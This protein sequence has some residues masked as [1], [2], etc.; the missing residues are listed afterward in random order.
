MNTNEPDRQPLDPLDEAFYLSV[1]EDALSAERLQP[2]AD[3]DPAQVE[4]LLAGGLPQAFE[5]ATANLMDVL[6]KQAPQQLRVMRQQQ[7]RFERR[8]RKRWGTA[9]DQY[10]ILWQCMQ[11]QGSTFNF[12]RG[13]G[14]DPLGSALVGLHAKACRVAWEV[15][16][17]LSAGLGMGALARC[18][19]LHEMAVLT[20]VLADWHGPAPVLI[21]D[22]AERFAARGHVI[23]Y[24][25]AL[26]YQRNAA[27]IDHEPFTDDEMD[28]FK[29]DRDAV[30]ARFGKLIAKRDYGWATG[31]GGF[32]QP[33]FAD[34]ETVA[35]LAHLRSYYKWA[36]HEVHA[37]AHGIAANLITH[38][39]GQA[40]LAGPSNVGLAD[41]GQSA[42]ISLHQITTTM[43]VH[44]GSTPG[45]MTLVGL[46]AVQAML[47]R[48][49]HEFAE[50]ERAIRRD[51][52]RLTRRRQRQERRRL[53]RRN[54]LNRISRQ[55]RA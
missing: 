30:V 37:D 18:R 34:L 15:H 46:Q 1:L 32:E 25:D 21:P 19:T 7:R 17:L 11:E 24:K 10:R 6:G 39:G 23:A 44:G 49:R 41:P 8:L 35:G 48:A 31:V 38:N 53:A 9:L 26:E 2:D 42:L 36:S 5:N 50:V 40:L 28:A 52:E 14:D 3:L 22:L 51:E 4:T 29:R 47:D 13:P 16:T 43:L 33:T 27:T 20:S 55:H 54:L 45:P 12:A